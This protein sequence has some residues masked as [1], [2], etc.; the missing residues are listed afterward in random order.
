VE[1][2]VIEATAVKLWPYILPLPTDPQHLR[3]LL[4]S[5]FGSAIP[6]RILESM[7]SRKRT[8]Q[9]ELVE[10]LPCSNK[11]TLGHLRRLVET[12]ILNAGSYRKTVKG[13]GVWAK[14]YE[15]TLLGR[16]LLMLLRP[17]RRVRHPEIRELM[18]QTIELYCKSLARLCVELEMDP[19]VLI[20]KLR[21]AYRTALLQ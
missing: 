6:L 21:D 9:K 19:Q 14:W 7:Y 20:R 17:S 15:P 12:G 18:T 8:F 5:F 16:W 13:K 1:Y 10:T 11:T 2:H 4:F 3:N